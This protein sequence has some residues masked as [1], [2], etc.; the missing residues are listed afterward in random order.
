[1]QFQI[2]LS[3][4][5]VQVIQTG[6]IQPIPKQFA[7]VN[8]ALNYCIGASPWGASIL[9][10]AGTYPLNGPVALM[11]Y[12]TIEGEEASDGTPSTHFNVVN[13]S[14]Q[15]ENYCK[16][17]ASNTEIG[18]A[19]CSLD[20]THITIKNLD[21]QANNMANYV[22][23]FG[24]TSD[25]LVSNVKVA[26]PI[27]T[28]FGHSSCVKAVYDRCEAT[29]TRSPKLGHGFALG[30]SPGGHQDVG[31][32]VINCKASGFNNPSGGQGLMI[33]GLRF[34]DPAS[35]RP[36]LDVKIIGGSFSNNL[37]G[38]WVEDATNLLIK[39]VE[40]F[41]NQHYGI[42]VPETVIPKEEKQILIDGGKCH[43]N[44]N[45]SNTN[46]F[47]PT[48]GVR[49]AGMESMIQ[50]VEMWD[51]Q[52]NNVIL[53]GVYLYVLNNNLNSAHQ[54]LPQPYHFYLFPYN[55]AP[56]TGWFIHNKVGPTLYGDF[57]G[58]SQWI[59]YVPPQ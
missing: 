2:S 4:T 52:P 56:L 5:N 46:S 14:P 16:G 8:D 42:F 45:N 19:F 37:V 35:R 17:F 40:T 32:T 21:I 13:P 24:R 3:G 59:H 30:G 53:D 20:K 1:M 27:A 57:F 51:N 22:F 49:I 39:D 25:I 43:K 38:V 10:K 33:R 26:D 11:S 18:N 48:G 50:N 6:A 7:S 55:G 54:R 23:S 31:T 9:V 34:I 36:N 28:A 15:P 58:D 29:T 12:L 41:S 47:G 44:G